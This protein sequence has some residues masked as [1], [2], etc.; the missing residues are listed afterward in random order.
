MCLV[1]GGGNT[2]LPQGHKHMFFI[3]K[4]KTG[5]RAAHWNDIRSRVRTHEGELLDGSKGRDYQQR[6]AKKYLGRDM[7]TPP[8]TADRVEQF[9]K[10]KR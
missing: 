6:W 3:V 10:T 9:E 8:V 7:N 5:Q 4:G 1:S 2:L